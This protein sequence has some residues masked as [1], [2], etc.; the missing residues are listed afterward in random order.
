MNFIENIHIFQHRIV[1]SLW[2]LARISDEI[3]NYEWCVRVSHTEIWDGHVESFHRDISFFFLS[4]FLSFFLFFL[5][6]LN[7]FLRVIKMYLWRGVINFL[8]LTEYEFLLWDIVYLITLM[9]NWNPGLRSYKSKR[10]KCKNYWNFLLE[11]ESSLLSELKM[12]YIMERF[13]VRSQ[14]YDDQ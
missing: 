2:L 1:V 9:N 5:C 13:L 8:H 3:V 12:W 4:F 11:R 7:I 10:R 6:N 14:W